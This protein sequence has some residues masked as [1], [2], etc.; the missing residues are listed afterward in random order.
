MNYS[1]PEIRMIRWIKCVLGFFLSPWLFSIDT[2][3][4]NTIIGHASF[5]S[6][7]IRNFFKDCQIFLYYP[8]ES[9]NIFG[10]GQKIPALMLGWPLIY[11]ASEACSGQVGFQPIYYYFTFFIILNIF[12]CKFRCTIVAIESLLRW[13]LSSEVFRPRIKF[14][15]WATCF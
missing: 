10:L 11:C 1:W 3:K 7:W 6:L 13:C 14:P 4:L 9:K 15:D 2:I 5:W 8:I 12:W